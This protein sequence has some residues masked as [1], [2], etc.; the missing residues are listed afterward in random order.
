MQIILMQYH[1]RFHGVESLK[2]KNQRVARLVKFLGGHSDVAASET[3]LRE[4]L[5]H[6]IL[7]VL[8]VAPNRKLLDQRKQQLEVALNDRL[9]AEILDLQQQ[10][11]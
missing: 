9:D 7:S 8:V 10:F 4:E 5:D 3:E 2:D 11:L 6:S 1:I